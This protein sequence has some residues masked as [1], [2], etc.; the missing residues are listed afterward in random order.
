MTEFHSKT[1]ACY[2]NVIMMDQE[3]FHELVLRMANWTENNNTFCRKVIHSG[4]QPLIKL[5][6]LATEE[7]YWGLIYG[8]A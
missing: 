7:T 6:Y 3:M 8:S 4:T 1:V 2:R 5:T